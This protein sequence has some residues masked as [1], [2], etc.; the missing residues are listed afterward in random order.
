M[1]AGLLLESFPYT[2]DWWKNYPRAQKGRFLAENVKSAYRDTILSELPW[3]SAECWQFEAEA[4]LQQARKTE[5]GAKLADLSP[6]SKSQSPNKWDQLFGTSVSLEN[7]DRNRG[8]FGYVAADEHNSSG[9]MVEVSKKKKNAEKLSRAFRSEEFSLASRS[10]WNA[11]GKFTEGLEERLHEL[12]GTV[13]VLDHRS[14]SGFY[15][16]YALLGQHALEQSLASYQGES[17]DLDLLSF[18]NLFNSVSSGTATY[19]PYVA[20]PLPHR[21]CINEIIQNP[22]PSDIL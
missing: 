8:S 6:G 11:F 20:K 14:I 21:H 19:A 7:L 13:G 3:K 15:N 4:A 10:T 2:R 1:E 17:F 12:E 16:A 22:R 5:E 18:G 9:V